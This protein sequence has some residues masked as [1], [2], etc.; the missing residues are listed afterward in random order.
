MD[1]MRMGH[2]LDEELKISVA[3]STAFFNI[4]MFPVFNSRKKIVGKTI[5]VT[6][7]TEKTKLLQKLHSL[8]S[9]DDLTDIYN[10]RYFFELLEME[11]E[12]AHRKK[13]P[14]SLI[15]IDLDK[16]KLVNDNHGHA[17]GDTV[18]KKVAAFCKNSLRRFDILGRYG[19]EEF[20]VF[21][22]ETK[23][24]EAQTVAE[25]IRTTIERTPITIGEKSISVT[26]SFGIASHESEAEITSDMLF[27]LADKALYEAKEKGRNR[28][29]TTSPL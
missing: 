26:S 8:A 6:D 10:R 9:I 11:I 16:F 20:I 4:R 13:Q 12:R 14:L 3:G 21:L 15:L 2:Q 1:R 23:L 27:A 18:L 7:V 22:P 24:S 5:L 28:V 29:I 25:R 19:G 17:A